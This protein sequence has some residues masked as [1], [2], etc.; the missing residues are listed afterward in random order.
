MREE[1][2][3]HIGAQ[4]RLDGS[5]DLIVVKSSITVD[6]SLK[7]LRQGLAVKPGELMATWVH[8][9]EEVRELTLPDA[10]LWVAMTIPHWVGVRTVEGVLVGLGEGYRER[11]ETE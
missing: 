9:R 1:V 6:T 11:V 10:R 8:Y 2:R 7:I 5:G 4:L 3:Y